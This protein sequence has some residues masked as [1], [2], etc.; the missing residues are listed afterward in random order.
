MS[1]PHADEPPSRR[2][3][4]QHHAAYGPRPAVRLLRKS[5]VHCPSDVRRTEDVER[6]DTIAGI[7]TA[8]RGADCGCDADETDQRVSGAR[9]AGDAPQMG[10]AETVSP[11]SVGWISA[12]SI[13]AI[14]DT[15]CGIPAAFHQPVA[16][17]R[18]RGAQETT[19]NCCIAPTIL[20]TVHSL[21]ECAKL[22]REDV[23]DAIACRAE[24]EVTGLRR[25]TAGDNRISCHESSRRT[26]C[27]SSIIEGDSNSQN[28]AIPTGREIP[29]Y[30]Y[31]YEG[32][33]I[34]E[35]STLSAFRNHQHWHVRTGVVKGWD[36]AGSVS[37]RD[38][39][40]GAI[41][42]LGG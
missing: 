21:L 22:L 20:G 36:A 10:M 3:L 16:Q 8:L 33:S 31:R 35:G 39:G 6:S 11:P 2:M 24:H 25:P 17:Q 7:S 38:N 42:V 1:F 4:R 34:R 30:D 5:V 15:F 41:P 37:C 29:E 12:S 32:R 40:R 28:T 19:R 27:L 14:R 9:G 26:S 23:P 18:A 13:R